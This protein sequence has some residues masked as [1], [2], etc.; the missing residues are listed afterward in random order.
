M[1][2]FSNFS[3]LLYK[4]N[5]FSVVQLTIRQIKCLCLRCLI[6]LNGLQRLASLWYLTFSFEISV[7]LLLFKVWML[8]NIGWLTWTASVQ[9]WSG[10]WDKKVLICHFDHIFWTGWYSPIFLLTERLGCNK[11]ERNIN[12]SHRHLWPSGWLLYSLSLSFFEFERYIRISQSSFVIQMRLIFMVY[13][14]LSR[15][16]YSFTFDHIKVRRAFSHTVDSRGK[17]LLL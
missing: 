1:F 15:S 6:M 13:V 14:I 9:S 8:V 7:G 10:C 5:N 16:W 2:D 11:T 4:I 17:L 3:S 12:T